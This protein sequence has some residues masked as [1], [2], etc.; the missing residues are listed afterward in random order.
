MGNKL[1]SRV[2]TVFGGIP[3]SQTPASDNVASRDFSL[4]DTP[5]NN[6]RCS[7][8]VPREDAKQRFDADTNLVVLL[9]PLEADTLKANNDVLGSDSGELEVVDILG[10]FARVDSLKLGASAQGEKVA[11]KKVIYVRRLSRVR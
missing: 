2:R 5:S 8:I 10:N 4:S 1:A 9:P 3:K 11:N 6:N 7:Q